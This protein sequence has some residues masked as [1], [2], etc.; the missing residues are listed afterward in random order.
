M[1][2]T[3]FFCFLLFFVF[4]LITAQEFKPGKVSIAEL[5]QKRHPKDSS[6]AAAILYKKG[7]SAIEY[8]QQEGFVLVTQVEARII[9]IMNI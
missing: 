4:S 3:K 9:P 6:A 1:K 2:F 8:N 5:E 7:K